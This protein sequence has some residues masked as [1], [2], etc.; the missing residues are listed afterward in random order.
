[1]TVAL[2]RFWAIAARVTGLPLWAGLAPAH[3][4]AS[5]DRSLSARSRWLG[6]RGGQ[7]PVFFSRWAEDWTDR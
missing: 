6:T 4:R 2:D 1:M 5:A 3:A 7:R